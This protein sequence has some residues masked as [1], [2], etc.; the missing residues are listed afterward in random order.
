LS[1]ELVPVGR[2]VAGRGRVIAT[3][4]AAVEDGEGAQR[5]DQG[6][7]GRGDDGREGEA[8]RRHGATVSPGR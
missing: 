7:C 5:R 8:A 4:V 2:A 3:G 1:G 6:E